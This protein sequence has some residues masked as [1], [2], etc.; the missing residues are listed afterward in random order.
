MLLEAIKMATA[1]MLHTG[2]KKRNR[3]GQ[4]KD[5]C[6]TAN[7]MACLSG[8]KKKFWHCLSLIFVVAKA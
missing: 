6:S 5:L 2:K 4:G 8:G 1:Y 3:T 7:V